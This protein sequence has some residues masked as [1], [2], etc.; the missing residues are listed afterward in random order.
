[1]PLYY[2]IDK[3]SNM[4]KCDLHIHSKYSFDS[5]A[6][7]KKIV[8]LALARG[9]QCV[10]IADHGNIKGCLEARNY[11]QK[12]NLPILAIVAEEVKSKQGDILALNIK[13]RIPDHLPADEVFQ[14]I[15]K[16]GGMSVIAHPFGLFCGFKEKLENYLGRFDGIEI[17]NS[18]V[19]AGNQT[20][21]EFA[22]KHNLLFTVGSDAHFVNRFI[23]GVWLE[24]PLNWS[25]D[26]TADQVIA[27][28]KQKTGNSAGTPQPFLSKA[29]DHSFRSLAKLKVLS[30][31]INNNSHL[32]K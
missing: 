22:K 21:K 24:L 23:G 20:A 17:I 26:L 3:I 18:S 19:F 27:A 11:I 29:L 30:G 7:P 10:A 5:L 1:L 25:P 31:K 28:I 13:E 2:F 15:K 9:I 32:G 14:E 16:Q 12:N 6:D 8:D 4:I